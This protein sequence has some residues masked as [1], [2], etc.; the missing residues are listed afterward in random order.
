M[1]HHR[2]IILGLL[3]F[4]SVINYLDRQSLSILARTIQNELGIS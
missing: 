4:A 3:F 1:K 2:W